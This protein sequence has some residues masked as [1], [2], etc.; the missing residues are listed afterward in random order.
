MTAEEQLTIE[1]LN[2]RIRQL[3]EALDEIINDEVD[4]DWMQ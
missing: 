3:K 4:F 1:V 2:N